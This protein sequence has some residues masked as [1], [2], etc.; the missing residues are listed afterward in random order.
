MIRSRSIA[1]LILLLFPATGAF[2]QSKKTIREKGIVKIT[3]Q[4][5]FLEEGMREPVVES[6]ETYNEE[7]DLLEIKEYNR[8]G[9]VRRWEKFSYNDEG[10]LIEE[11][12]LDDR[13]RVTSTEKTIYKDGLRV[14]KHFFNNR[15]QLV[16]KKEYQYE[17]SQ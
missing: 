15:G 6:E 8:R 17:Y 10:D 5:Y 13:G 3:V 12:F 4:E 7:G 9:E 14:E 16:K 2:G 1:I 11:V